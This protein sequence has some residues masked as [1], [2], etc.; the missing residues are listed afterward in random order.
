MPVYACVCLCMSVYV[1]V[2]LC[3]SVYVCFFLCCVCVRVC[4][5]VGSPYYMSPEILNREGYDTKCDVWSVGCVIAELMTGRHTFPNMGSVDELRVHLLEQ[6]TLDLPERFCQGL[7]DTVGLCL[8][9]DPKKRPSCR[10]LLAMKDVVAWKTTHGL[11]ETE[12]Q[13]AL[14][15]RARE[16]EVESLKA[17]LGHV[18]VGGVE[19]NDG[20]SA[21]GVK[22]GTLV[23]GRYRP[24]QSVPS[25][26]IHR[27]RRRLSLESDRKPIPRRQPGVTCS[28]SRADGMLSEVL[29]SP[30]SARRMGLSRKSGSRGFGTNV[31]LTGGGVHGNGVLSNS[32]TPVAMDTG[33]GSEYTTRRRSSTL[34]SDQ[35]GL[36]LACAEGQR[37]GQ[38]ARSSGGT[39]PFTDRTTGHRTRGRDSIPGAV[40]PPRSARVV[41]EGR[42]KRASSLDVVSAC[43]GE[44]GAVPFP[45]HA[46]KKVPAVDVHLRS[47]SASPPRSRPVN[48]FVHKRASSESDTIDIPPTEEEALACMGHFV[49]ETAARDVVDSMERELLSAKMFDTSD[50]TSRQLVGKHGKKVARRLILL[51]ERV[52]ALRRAAIYRSA[53]NLSQV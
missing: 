11:I 33:E 52:V 35:F 15:E 51:A 4:V 40:I 34:S 29:F 28:M 39:R 20:D 23:R 48:G 38:G 12:A 24:I 13:V 19:V 7:R 27:W 44:G 30:N 26:D 18:S 1:C 14:T 6:R 25:N 37:N 45:V 53:P 10:E 16:K 46:T 47:P 43:E 8:I 5:R 22:S 41:S 21:Y 50:Q 49:G 17:S 2:C 42:V 3:M 31:W 36:L 32:P 9:R